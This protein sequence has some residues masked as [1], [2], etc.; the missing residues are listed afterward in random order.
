M[1]IHAG[2]HA[3][4]IRTPIVVFSDDVLLGLDFDKKPVHLDQLTRLRHGVRISE[5]AAVP[6]MFADW[7]DAYFARRLTAVSEMKW[8]TGGTDL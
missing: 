1:K 4:P 5:L 2:H 6:A 7:L 3:Y 8:R